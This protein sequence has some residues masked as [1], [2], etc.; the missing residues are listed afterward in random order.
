MDRDKGR[1]EYC[2]TYLLSFFSKTE[3]VYFKRTQKKRENKELLIAISLE[4]EFI[5]S[6]PWQVLRSPQSF[7]LSIRSTLFF[8]NTCKVFRIIIVRLYGD[9]LK[10][11]RKPVAVVLV[12]LL[13]TRAVR[14][15]PSPSPS[16]EAER[17][18]ERES[19]ARTAPRPARLAFRPDAA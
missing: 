12:R 13:P 9:E 6:L 18:R 5:S 10:K 14:C 17:E 11:I 3:R 19:R 8:S 2:I 1:K 16:Q 15:S 7:E 4:S